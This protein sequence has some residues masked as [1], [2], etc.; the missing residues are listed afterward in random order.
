MTGQGSAE[1]F[2]YYILAEATSGL[3]RW[4]ACIWAIAATTLLVKKADKLTSEH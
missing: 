4:P 3:T 1:V 2:L